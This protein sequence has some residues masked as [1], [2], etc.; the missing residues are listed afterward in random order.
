MLCAPSWGGSWCFP[1]LLVFG[2]STKP[3][4]RIRL[5]AELLGHYHQQLALAYRFGP[6][7]IKSPFI[8]DS[9]AGYDWALIGWN[10]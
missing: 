1:S 8:W 4:I 10:S 9:R 5:F 2:L 7:A 3:L 6:R